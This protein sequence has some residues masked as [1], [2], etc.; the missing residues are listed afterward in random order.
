MRIT[1]A[2]LLLLLLFF[3]CQE[4]KPSV[5]A[6]TY[7]SGKIRGQG[8]MVD[9]LKIGEWVFWYENG[10]VRDTSNWTNDTL[11][12]LSVSFH[13]NGRKASIGQYEMGRKTGEWKWWDDKDHLQEWSFWKAGSPSGFATTY[14]ENG[15][16]R[17][18][19]EWFGGVLEGELKM[20]DA[21]GMLDKLIITDID[22][23]CE[24]KVYYLKE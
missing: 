5:T 22:N 17:T 15:I 3:G 23:T 10:T 14:Y 11:D 12:G 19:G 6:L 16:V 13:S 18:E 21:E 7:E 9:T 2:S 8:E 4:D 24:L 1:G 20:Y